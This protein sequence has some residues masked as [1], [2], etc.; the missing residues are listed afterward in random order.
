MLSTTQTA[1]RKP[2]VLG[3]LSIGLPAD[4][5]VRRVVVQLRLNT[6]MADAGNCDRQVEAIVI[7]VDT[8]ASSCR[9][10]SRDSR[11]T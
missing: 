2:E 9:L 10:D 7:P 3:D 1:R 8:D 5:T 4:A 6:R 11:R